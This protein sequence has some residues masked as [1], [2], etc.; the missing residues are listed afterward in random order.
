MKIIQSLAKNKFY[1][2][3]YS[4]PDKNFFLKKPDAYFCKI[5]KNSIAAVFCADFIVL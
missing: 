4:L 3:G 1:I 2:R 5:N